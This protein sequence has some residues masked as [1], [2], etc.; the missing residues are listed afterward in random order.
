[1]YNK[2]N[3]YE[4][5]IH[6]PHYVFNRRP[7]MDILDRAAQFSPFSAVV[8]HESIVKEAGRYTDLR[9]ELNETRKSIIDNQLRD[10][11]TQ[12]TNKFDVEIVYFQADELKT[13][14]KYIVKVGRVKK[15]DIYL[16]EIHMEDNTRIIIDDIYN[17]IRN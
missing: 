13:V 14:G 6:L 3:T 12:L 4:D 10:I 17:I 11:E 5:I 16:R 8:G 7:K 2:L 15:F 9:K 1:M